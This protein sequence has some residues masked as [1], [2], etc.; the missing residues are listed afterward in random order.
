MGLCTISQLKESKRLYFP[1]IGFI[2]ETKQKQG[3]VRTVCKRLG[4]KDRWDIVNSYGKS[5]GLL[6][7]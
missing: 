2:S 1:N 5:G 4:V 7:F 6:V 3:F